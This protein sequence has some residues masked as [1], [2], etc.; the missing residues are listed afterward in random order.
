M[1]KKEMVKKL[2]KIKKPK[3]V[4]ETVITDIAKEYFIE[5][6]TSMVKIIEMNGKKTTGVKT[7]PSSEE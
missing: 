4:K 3:A 5:D 1:V 7:I 6:G 2:K